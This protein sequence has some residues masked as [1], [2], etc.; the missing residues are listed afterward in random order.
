MHG[1]MDHHMT[2]FT[3]PYPEII[4]G[5]S[6]YIDTSGLKKKIEAIIRP[7]SEMS[8]AEQDTI[9]DVTVEEAPDDETSR[10]P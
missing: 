2:E 3:E 4:C 1:R 6:I 8:P 10:D 9:Q 5:Q 7:R